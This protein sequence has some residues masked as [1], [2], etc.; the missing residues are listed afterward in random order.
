MRT[1]IRNF[2]NDL[3]YR[4][5]WVKRIRSS[6]NHHKPRCPYMYYMSIL[7]VLIG[8][9]SEDYEYDWHP[10]AT[11][12]E[13]PYWTMDYGQGLGWDTCVFNGRFTWSVYSDGNL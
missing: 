11:G 1:I 10:L 4:I 8:P 6:K 7:C 13:R 12:D 5:E 3:K 2:I 9:F